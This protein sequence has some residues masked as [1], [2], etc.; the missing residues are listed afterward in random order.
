[1]LRGQQALPTTPTCTHTKHPFQGSWEGG[2]GGGAHN[3]QTEGSREQNKR[4]RPEEALA[5]VSTIVTQGPTWSSPGA[6]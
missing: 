1:M 3:Y 6:R 5:G 2:G 4:F